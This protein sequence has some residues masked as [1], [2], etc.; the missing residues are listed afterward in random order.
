MALKRGREEVGPSSEEDSDTEEEETLE[1]RLDRAE[2]EDPANENDLHDIFNLNMPL[3]ESFYRIGKFNYEQ[4]LIDP[5]ATPEKRAAELASAYSD[6]IVPK[7]LGVPNART[8]PVRQGIIN[9]WLDGARLLELAVQQRYGNL[10]LATTDKMFM[11]LRPRSDQRLTREE[12]WFWSNPRVDPEPLN[13]GMSN[14][15]HSPLPYFPSMRKLIKAMILRGT[16]DFKIIYEDV[17]LPYENTPNW[18][19]RYEPAG[20]KNGIYVAGFFTRV[21]NGEYVKMPRREFFETDEGFT[22]WIEL[23]ARV[24][25]HKNADFLLDRFLDS[26]G[27][28]DNSKIPDNDSLKILVDDFGR[29]MEGI[30]SMVVQASPDTINDL[31]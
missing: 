22:R 29:M 1:E 6:Y 2:E 13:R 10:P 9:R 19:R 17:R 16:P 5:P 18:A 27:I 30:S 23:E 21:G 7:F 25:G 11:K 3:E 28:T 8:L 15:L 4:N 24:Q 12:V 20:V 31:I 26:R 14:Q